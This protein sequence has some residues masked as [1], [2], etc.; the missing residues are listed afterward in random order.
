MP[1][2][3]T[4]KLLE[5]D[6][7]LNQRLMPWKGEKDP[8]KIW[9]SEVILQQTRVEQGWNY[10]NRFIEAFPTISALAYAEDQ[11][12]FKLWEGLGY[13]SRCRNLLATARLV[14]S[15]HNGVLPG[16]YQELIKLKGIGPYTASAISSFA[17][18]ENKAVVDGNV[19]RVLA[20]Y[21]GVSVSASTSAGKKFY[22]D[23]AQ[24][25]I[26]NESP[27]KYN[28]AIMDFG[29]L[30]CKPKQPACLQCI[31]STECEAF[32]LGKVAELPFKEPAMAKKHRWFNYFIL[33]SAHH[34]YLRER[35]AKDIWQHLYEFLLIET[36]DD[37]PVPDKLLKNY[38]HSPFQVY[39]ATKPYKQ[40]L[41]HQVIH[42]RFSRIVLSQDIN[43]EGFKAVLK[44]DIKQ[45][46][47]PRLISLFLQAEL[48]ER[49]DF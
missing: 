44:S 29:A 11:Q 38:L 30:I 32:R 48:P 36:S 14:M 16:T 1:A 43:I 5:W 10:Y 20:R 18:G 39:P 27:A 25:L 13:Y 2:L 24:S 31:Q 22:A 7:E 28:Q 4:S 45:F 37:L 8:Y 34:I 33:E 26:S 40:V 42:A 9:L 6:R 17:F 19:Q 15:E 46:P 47:F 49:T 12:V 41:S 35:T 21:F 3:F 23:L